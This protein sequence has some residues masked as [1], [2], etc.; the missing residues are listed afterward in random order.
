MYDVDERFYAEMHKANIVPCLRGT[1]NGSE[2]TDEDIAAGSFRV[3]NQNVQVDSINF[4]GVFVGEF[5]ATFLPSIVDSRGDWVGKKITCEYG[6]FYDEEEH[7]IPCPSYEYTINEANWTGDG[8]EVVAYD[9]MSLLDKRYTGINSVGTPWSWL[10][11][12]KEKTGIR[13]GLTE[14]EV[15]TMPN[16]TKRITLYAVENIK[17]YRDILSYLAQ[18]LGGF[19]TCDRSGRITIKQ[20]HTLANDTIDETKR[21]VGGRFSDYVTEYTS[22]SVINME[23]MEEE[24]TVSIPDDKLRMRLGANPFLQ[25]EDKQQKDQMRVPILQALQKFKYTPFDVTLLGCCAYDLGDVIQ[26]VGG[27]ADNY[28]GCIM[29]YDFGL[30]DYS[31]SGYGDNPA[32]VSALSKYDKNLSGISS[33]SKDEVGT[34]KVTN[35]ERIDF[36]SEWKDLGTLGFYASKEQTALFHGVVK[37]KVSEPGRVRVRYMLNSDLLGFVHEE[38]IHSPVDTMTLFLPVD[39]EADILES[40]KLQIQSDTSGYIEVLDMSGAVIGAGVFSSTWSGT[41]EVH[42]DFRRIR[43]ESSIVRELTDIKNL[44]FLRVKEPAATETFGRIGIIPAMVRP[45]TDA[46]Y[47]PTFRDDVQR[48]TEDGLFRAEEDGTIRVTSGGYPNG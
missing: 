8:L 46:A 15:S 38:Y 12:L 6:L 23:T 48:R 22:F 3:S 30:N 36:D 9:N 35:I 40:L 31:I 44:E 39:I 13:L 29:L 11:F 20:F 2:F 33:S 45:L 5:K 37:L 26:F 21:F 32:L 17:T 27:I 34:A 28:Y 47:L 42:D 25:I 41:I 4:G 24:A 14:Q 7:Y 43:N 19:A 16:G 1:I 18:V 10:N